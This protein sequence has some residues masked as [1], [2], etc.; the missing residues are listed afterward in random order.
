MLQVFLILILPGAIG[1]GAAWYL[2]D[3]LRAMRWNIYAFTLIMGLLVPFLVGQL[4]ALALVNMVNE[5]M[6]LAAPLL[7]GVAAG[8]SWFCFAVGYRLT[9]GGSET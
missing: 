7:A 2:R 8:A 1:A 9:A 4:A 5:A 6:A 3:R